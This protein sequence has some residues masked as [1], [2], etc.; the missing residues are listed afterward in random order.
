MY[1]HVYEYIYIYI[2]ICIHPKK[3]RVERHTCPSSSC[4]HADLRPPDLGAILVL[5]EDV[6]GEV[7]HGHGDCPEQG[8]EYPLGPGGEDGVLVI[9]L[10]AGLLAGLYRRGVGGVEEASLVGEIEEGLF[11]GGGSVGL[12]ELDV[13][14][15]LGLFAFCHS[16]RP[17]VGDG[18]VVFL[19]RMRI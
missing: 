10:V 4:P 3:R 7:Q 13:L 16:G 1:A 5:D 2:Y 6:K 9:V 19:G 18:C 11:G 12:L 15:F 17:L 14:Y 8:L